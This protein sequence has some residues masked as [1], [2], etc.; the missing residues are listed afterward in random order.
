MTLR[1][2]LAYARPY[3]GALVVAMLLML[4]ETAAALAVPWFGGLLAGGVLAGATVDVGTI[5][6]LLIAL[7]AVQAVLAVVSRTILGRIGERILADLR[8]RVYDHLQALP[9][10]FF[11]ERRRGDLLA[12]VTQEVAQL[13]HFLS[14][15]LVG[16][17]PLLVTA[18]G[19]A[20]LMVRL[21]P[22]LGLAVAVLVPVFYLILKVLGRR[23]RPL[24]V[25]TQRQRAAAMAVA[26]E[27]IAML[28]VIKAFAQEGRASDRHARR[29]REVMELVSTQLRIQ[30]LIGPTIRFLAA[31]AVVLLLWLASARIEAGTLGPAELVSF[32]LYAALLTRPVGGLAGVY[33]SIQLARGSLERLQG[34][35][36]DRPEADSAGGC[37]LARVRGEIAF[38]DVHFAYPGRPPALTGLTLRIAAG[39]IVAVTGQNGAGKSTLVHLLMRLHRPTAGTIRIDGVDIASVTLPSL[40]RQIGLVPQ[41]VLLLHAS[42]RE[43]IAF[44][45]PQASD[46]EVEAA[47][48]AAQAPE[49]ILRL[50]EGYDTVIGDQGARLSGGQ[51]QRLALARALLTDPPI[52]ILDEATAMF[53]P[54]GERSLTAAFRTLLAGRTVIV[55]THRPETL[56]L[57]DRVVRLEAGR[58]VEPEAPK[59]GGARREEAAAALRPY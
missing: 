5:V 22:R 12:L 30:A 50:P 39:E 58:L 21:E 10:G 15:T 37:T 56:S 11:Q 2:L 29:V 20:V 53:D 47:A 4:A 40:R 41:Q 38:E 24:A 59:A 46:A 16:T 19:A 34:V 17:I 36:D 8:I 52:L 14:G 43:N 25:E 57:A 18:A 32:L 1:H 33:G 27:N 28:P 13:S 51:R 3:R 54:E 7:F 44:G 23:L 42:V 49:M 48:K 55:I 6:A 9:I 26:Q 35:L 45:R 31:A